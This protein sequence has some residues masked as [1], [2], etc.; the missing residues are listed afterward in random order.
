[1]IDTLKTKLIDFTKENVLPFFITNQNG[2]VIADPFLSADASQFLFKDI[3]LNV[4]QLEEIIL[5]MGKTIEPVVVELKVYKGHL[6][7]GLMAPL[8]TNQ[9]EPY[10]LWSGWF[11]DQNGTQQRLLDT[12]IPTLT[13]EQK[14]VCLENIRECR[15]ICLSVLTGTQHD[16]DVHD[17]SSYLTDLLMKGSS[18]RDLISETKLRLEEID[19]IGLALWTNNILTIEECVAPEHTFNQVKFMSGEGYIGK[20]YATGEEECWDVDGMDPRAV[21]FHQ[22]KMPIKSIK[23]SPVKFENHSYGVLFLGSYS[24]TELSQETKRSSTVLASFLS[25]KLELT[26]MTEREQIHS[27]QLSAFLEMIRNYDHINDKKLIASLLLDLCQNVL[28]TSRSF[29]YYPSDDANEKD[30][31]D[32]RGFTLD[33][34]NLYKKDVLVRLKENNK[35]PLREPE[36][37]ETVMNIKMFECMLWNEYR[38][39][40][41]ML[42]IEEGL[43]HNEFS[44][45]YLQLIGKMTNVALNRINRESIVQRRSDLLYEAFS[46]THPVN[47]QCYQKA[48]EVAQYF[49]EQLNE[50]QDLNKKVTEAIKLADYPL[51]FL[52]RIQIEPD[53]MEAI[54]HYKQLLEHEEAIQ[55]TDFGPL[56]IY[57]SIQYGKSDREDQF[58]EFLRIKMK[59]HPLKEVFLKG[60]EEKK[61]VS[62]MNPEVKGQRHRFLK[63]FDQLTSREL[64]ILDMISHGLKNHEIS[65]LLYISQNTVKNHIQNIYKKLGIKNRSQATTIF[66]TANPVAK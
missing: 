44:Y 29:I 41:G 43:M 14:L 46:I 56:I 31:L 62:E 9:K 60:L 17:L 42:C 40:P 54:E 53:V 33:E 3:E 49:L 18:A 63:L 21:L 12:K 51:S 16:L 66:L 36:I 15:D 32:A 55:S 34:M 57:L 23:C 30:I 58:I 61:K 7:K 47:Y 37:K 8:L 59:D 64:E 65:Q 27:F 52:K 48:E 20:V 19:F 6:I 28:Q 25:I 35:K 45:I 39:K 2:H 50:G 22:N 24:S 1:M 26:K 4:T 11:I 13:Q 10:F 38:G 5:V